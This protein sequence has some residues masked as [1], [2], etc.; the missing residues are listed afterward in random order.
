MNW[1][2]AKYVTKN[3]NQLVKEFH[4]SL[5]VHIFF[6]E[7]VLSIGFKQR[8]VL[9][10]NHHIT[11]WMHWRSPKLHIINYYVLSWSLDINIIFFYLRVIIVLVAPN[12]KFSTLKT[13]SAQ[14][15]WTSIME[16]E[17]VWVGASDILLVTN[18]KENQLQM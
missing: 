13:I 10:Y 7:N 3:T 8:L 15:I 6:A 16:I 14:L 1:S 2:H 12:A 9:L 4:A 11:C 18:N 5:N 17:F